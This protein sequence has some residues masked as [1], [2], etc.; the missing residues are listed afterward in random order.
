MHVADVMHSRSYGVQKGGAATHAVLLIRHR[1]YLLD[2]HPVVNDFAAIGE[3]HRGE[4][5]PTGF[6]LLLFHHCVETADGVVLEACHGSAA[7]QDEYYF[8]KIAVH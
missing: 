7:V 2:I 8:C 6:F 4:K 1:L 3:Q 5:S